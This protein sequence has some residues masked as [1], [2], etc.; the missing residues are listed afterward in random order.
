[1]S[2]KHFLLVVVF[3][4]LIDCLSV[5]LSAQSAKDYLKIGMDY[6][7]EQNYREALIRFEKAIGL[8]PQMEKA[9]AERAYAYL[10]LNEKSLAADDYFKA[11]ELNSKKADYY[12]EAGKLYLAI[13]NFSQSEIALN[14]A[15][16]IDSKHMETLQTKT[17][18]YLNT[19]DFYKASESANAALGIKKTLINTYWFGVVSDSLG[20]LDAA[21]KAFEEIIKGNYLYE[22]AY[23]G[24]ANVQLQLFQ[25]HTSPYMKVEQL[26]KALANCNTVLELYPENIQGYVL[27]SKAYYYKSEFSRA[28][29][30]ISRAIARKQNDKDLHMSRGIY[31]QDFGQQQNAIND[32]NKVIMMESTSAS[33]YYR[34]GMAYEAIFNHNKAL[35]DYE[36]ALALSEGKPESARSNFKVARDRILEL[37]RENDMP[38]I[39]ITHPELLNRVVYLR[40]DQD[41]LVVNGIVKDKS[42]IKYIKVNREHAQFDRET[43]NPEF[44]FHMKL[45][46]VNELLFEAADWYDNRVVTAVSV[47]YT[48]VNAPFVHITKPYASD[49]GDLTLDENLT[50]IAIEGRVQDESLIKSI[51]INGISASYA[52][53]QLNPTFS[54]FI[55]ITNKDKITVSTT[56]IYNNELVSEY[57]IV[58][59]G[60]TIASSNPMGTT[61]AVFIENTNYQ[62][63]ASIDGPAKDVAAMKKAL[64][65]YEIHKIIHKKNL[66]KEQF[67]RFFAIELRDLIRQNGVNSVLVWYAGHGKFVNES[68]YWI[69][70]DAKRDD[71]FT[72]FKVNNLKASL[73]SY[74]K[75]LTH[76]LVVSDACESGPSFY[77]AMRG[78]A[79]DK[80]CDD[81]EASG[82]KSSQVLTSTGYELAVQQSIFTDVF[83]RALERNDN[84]CIPI[85]EVFH[86]INSEVRKSNQIARFG[87][88]TGLEDQNGTF[89]FIRKD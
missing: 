85:D 19:K 12:C 29:D 59:Q 67:E 40:N 81:F 7:K 14:K 34:R 10:Q 21:V 41:S 25:K 63:F 70:V 62:D 6:N 77:E 46:G 86:K 56:D 33:A 47:V 80:R 83:S 3:A 82:F 49:T 51:L 87:K 17:L 66:T 32:F 26:E 48:E 79:K 15:N 28:I 1:M 75:L 76:T 84:T 89:F 5:S 35:G 18:L 74:S 68:G 16:A 20:N 42:K 2:L 69:P 22:N 38:E 50:K 36:E 57:K 30:D 54:A 44:S 37:N 64:N 4:G 24:L 27:R 39:V 9:Y 11:G 78:D 65:N 8:E 31:Y 43:T 71:E 58:R 88:I 13:K 52:V 73:E 60:R 55:D 72:Y 53:D 23:T 61:W 45:A